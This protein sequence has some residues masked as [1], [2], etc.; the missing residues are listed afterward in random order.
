MNMPLP[1]VRM[2]PWMLLAATLSVAAGCNAPT[3]SRV[4]IQPPVMDGESVRFRT[5]SP[6]LK[7]LRSEVVTEQSRESIRLPARVIWDETRTVR[8]YAPLSGRIMRL[9]AQPGDAV[10]AGAPLAMLASPDLGQAQA[11]ARRATVDLGLAEKNLARAAELHE[12]GVIAL[13]DLHL[14]QADQGRA[15]AERMRASARLKLYTGSE[16]VDQEFAIRAP[17]GGVVVERNANPGQEVRSDQSG[18]AAL[19]VLSDPAHLWVQIDAGET[20]LKALRVGEPVLLSSPALGERTFKARIEQIA[21][22]FDPQTRT[23][24]VRASV[25]NSAR[26]LKADMFVS[27]EIEVD[28]GK[29]IQVPETTVM[30]RGETQ[31]VFV[32]EGEGRF[33]RQVVTAEEAGFGLM[34]VRTG[35]KSGDR[36]VMDGGLLLMQLFTRL[37]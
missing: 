18:N 12:H 24:R 7:V 10:K 5:D 27:A 19:F 30:L 14:A 16:S 33:R 1:V 31:Y 34:R 11:D 37:R 6:Q 20:A 2:R 26:Q 9:L 3:E 28:R 35:L 23:V 29:F 21:D 36:V 32:D 8:I 17:I 25:D 15:E 4:T 22:F 13:K